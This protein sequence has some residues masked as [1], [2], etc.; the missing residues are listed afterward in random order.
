MRPMETTKCPR[1]QLCVAFLL[2]LASQLR[3][4]QRPRPTTSQPQA[5]SRIFH[6]P[7]KSTHLPRPKTSLMLTHPRILN[8]LLHPEPSGT[9]SSAAAKDLPHLYLSL[10]SSAGSV[11]TTTDTAKST[12][13]PLVITSAIVAMA[14]AEI[15]YNRAAKQ[16]L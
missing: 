2:N 11:T 4:V 3:T 5:Q 14:T 1:V 15:R 8:A 13:D 16:D 9:A 7:S 12:P 10:V 6:R